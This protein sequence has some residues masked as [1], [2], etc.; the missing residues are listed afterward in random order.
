[1]CHAVEIPLAGLVQFLEGVDD[2]NR[3][4]PAPAAIFEAGLDIR[5]LQFYLEIPAGGVA[6]DCKYR[7][8]I[9]LESI[10]MEETEVCDIRIIFKS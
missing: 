4:I 3:L 8:F 5:L 10:D 1:M 7:E 9:H 2:H 6:R